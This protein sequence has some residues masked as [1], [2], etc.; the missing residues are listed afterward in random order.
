[1]D[2]MSIYN[3]VRE[4]PIEAQK[5]I[6]GGR[7]AG[8][9]DINPQWRYEMLTRTFGAAGVGWYFTIDKQWIEPGANG[10]IAAMC[11]I[12]L[13]L[14]N[15]GEWS[16]PIQGTGGSMFI[17]NE[18]SGARTSDEAFKMALTDALSVACKV[19]GIG[20]NI[21]WQ[22]SPTKHTA[23]EQPK[24][25]RKAQ[26]AQ[27]TPAPVQAEKPV[28]PTETDPAMIR[29][30]AVSIK[31]LFNDCEAQG[32]NVPALCTMYKVAQLH[33]LSVKQYNHIISNWDR[34]KNMV[35]G[36]TQ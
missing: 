12:S 18:K 11:N 6:T 10:E 20:A 1:M 3:A 22:N 9:T 8:F 24:Q 32:V 28:Q 21:Y 36:V 2:N 33:E 29:A 25:T 31:Q 30:D 4:C 34:V 35:K 23:I 16:K 27:P 13:Y 14:N 5:K 17:A 26:A 19:I 7:L 15:G